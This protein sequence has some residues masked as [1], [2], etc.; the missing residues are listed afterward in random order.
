MNA[1]TLLSIAVVLPLAHAAAVAL[2]SRPS[3]LRDVA[4]IVGAAPE[5]VIRHG[6]AADE[7]R[8][9]I[10]EDRA[11][12]ILVLASGTA[13]EGPGPLVSLVAGP[14]G[15]FY[16]IPVTVVPGSLSEAEVDAIT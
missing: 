11:I 10:A 15:G 3:G 4:H 8:A 12:S 6:R 9:L 16:P 7:V 14:S 2:L 5:R 1:A 13:K